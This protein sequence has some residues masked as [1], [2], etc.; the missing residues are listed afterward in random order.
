MAENDI[1]LDVKAA[2]TPGKPALIMGDTGEVVSFAQLNAGANAFARMLAGHGLTKGDR[3]SLLI[4]NRPELLEA[5]WAGERSGLYYTALPTHLSAGEIAYIIQDSGAK[6]FVTTSRS[7]AL[8]TELRALLPDDL[9]CYSVE[10]QPA[11][12]RPLSEGLAEHAD[13]P[14][15]PEATGRDLL[16]SSGT[17]GKPKGVLMPQIE[18]PYGSP[19]PFHTIFGKRYELDVDTVYLSPAPLYHAAPLRMTIAVIGLGGT[20]VVMSKFDP[21]KALALIERYQITHSQW[22]P[23]MFI[24][25]LDLPNEMRARYD[26]SSMRCAIHAAAPCPVHVKRAMID[27]WG[28]VIEEY[29]ASTEGAGVCVVNSEEWLAH[30]GTV[31]R[32][33]RGALHIT[34]DNAD[35]LPVGEVG[36]V[37]F[38]T[39]AKFEYLNDPGKTASITN[40]HGWITLGDVG[41]MDGDGYLYLTDRKSFMIISGGVNIYPQE[42]E[43][44][45]LTHPNVADVAVIGVPNSEMGEEVKAV[46]VLRDAAVASAEDLIAFCRQSLSPVKCPRSV[47]FIDALPRSD[48]GKLLKAK[49][50]DAY[51]KDHA[52][53]I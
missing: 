12:Y 9:P 38:E 25:M 34:D 18:A 8:L 53:R 48:T 17:T 46:V 23:T 6:L 10:I 42:T 13:T 1:R 29:Y 24:R 15:L 14:M 45:L 27:W 50:K 43:N 51:W 19:K 5:V 33:V 16:Y 39:E 22:V 40:K 3:Y 21:E 35:D 7:E 31:G 37:Y 44:V 36:D 32:A 30:P 41:Y 26:V 11:G 20:A 49:L 28:P 2:R 4:E 47:D 52:A